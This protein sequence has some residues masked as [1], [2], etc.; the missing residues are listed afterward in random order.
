MYDFLLLLYS[1]K[2]ICQALFRK[3][4]KIIPRAVSRQS[5]WGKLPGKITDRAWDRCGANYL[6]RLRRL[7]R[8]GRLGLR[9]ILGMTRDHPSWLVFLAFVAFLFL[10]VAPT[11]LTP[12]LWLAKNGEKK[13]FL[14]WHFSK[15]IYNI[16]KWYIYQFLYWDRTW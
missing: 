15:M 1:G 2:I 4:T 6:R 7:R 10:T 11:P 5:N 16:P 13:D 8:L 14:P 12:Y 9:A 3:K